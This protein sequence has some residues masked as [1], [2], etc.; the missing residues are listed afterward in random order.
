MLTAFLFLLYF[1]LF[2][3]L[4]C[5]FRDRKSSSPVPVSTS[6]EN[7]FLDRNGNPLRGA[8]LLARKKKL[9]LLV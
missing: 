5:G 9:G 6:N 4:I 2:S 8:A 1:L 3:S 7:L